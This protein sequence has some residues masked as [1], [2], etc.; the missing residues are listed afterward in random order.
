M[1]TLKPEFWLAICVIVGALVYL[2]AD[3]QMPLTRMGDALG[4]RAFPAL[5][6]CGLLLAGALLLIEAFSKT[7]I[8]KTSAHTETETGEPPT[9][10]ERL[11]QSGILVAMVAWTALYY[12]VFEE[13][14][15]LVSTMVFLG[16][17]LS[18]FHRG[19]HRANFLTAVG[20][21]LLVNLIFT[22]LLN[23]PLP[24]G[25]FAI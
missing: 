15:Y 1:K 11:R 16:A 24:A 13:V 3:Y 21:A 25:I 2:Y 23:V 12:T 8:K 5:V 6:G 9:P 17:L 20:F 22:H 10:K 7:E 18:Y 14:G 19:H 4:P